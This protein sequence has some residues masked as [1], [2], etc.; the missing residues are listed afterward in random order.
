VSTVLE[1][2]AA[3]VFIAAY[4][5]TVQIRHDYH[6]IQGDEI[7]YALRKEDITRDYFH[8]TASNWNTSAHHPLTG[9][10]IGGWVYSRFDH[11]IHGGPKY[12]N[13]FNIW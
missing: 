10:Q 11:V 8:A 2:I 12:T 13:F 9:N 3:L 7:I 5:I 1:N 6:E 4:S